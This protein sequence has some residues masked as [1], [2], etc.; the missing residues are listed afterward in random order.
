MK[1]FFRN[2]RS[3]ISCAVV[4]AMIGSMVVSCSYDDSKLW[5]EIETIKGELAEL[6]ASVESELAAIRAI[7]E[8]SITIK[9]VE[10]QADGSKVITLSDN[11]K[12]TVYPKGDKVPSDI[13]T[14]VDID[15]VKYW[16]MFDKDGNAYPIMVNNNYVKVADVAPQ[17]RINGDAIEISFDGGE[18][19]LTTGYTQSAADSIISNIE[20]VYSDW[21]TD[22]KGNPLALYSVI[23]LVDGSVV[24]VGMQNGKLVLPYDTVFVAYETTTP[25][26]IEVADAA[27]FMTTTPDGWECD[28]EHDTKSG[29]MTLYFTAP[30]EA[31]VKSGMAEAEGVA[32][33]FVSFNSGSAAIASIKLSTKPATV[34][35]TTKGV[36]IEAAYG[37][38]YLLCGM[39]AKSEYN[40]DA[41]ARE[42][43]AQLAA[44]SSTIEGIVQIAFT[45]AM[46]KFV[47]YEELVKGELK[48]GAEYVF[49]CVAPVANEAGDLS[50][51][52]NAISTISKKY[53]AV[54]FKV[55]E[56][57][58]FDVQIAF[59]VVGS[60]PYALDYALASEFDAKE[61]AAHYTANP[62]YLV[63]SHKDMSYEGSFLEL[64]G[65]NRNL[66]SGSRYVAWYVAKN[67]N[68]VYTEDNILSWEFSTMS[69]DASGDIEIIAGDAV[70]DYDSI[71]V[72]LDTDEPHM[73]IYY[74][75]MPSYMASAYPD[76]T[77]IIEMLVA[78]GTK[79]VTDG[80]VKARY[81]DCK[82]GDKIT[83]FAVAVDKAGKLGKPFKQEY[84][85]KT[86]EYNSLELRLE[87]V[88]SQANNT[89]IKV[90]S[91]GAKSFRYIYAPVK[92][93]EWT[94]MFGGS[95]SK[96]GE[97]FVKNPDSSYIYDTADSNHALVDGN[98]LI[99]GLM[100]DLEYVVVVVA[101]DEKGLTSKPKSVYF[102]PT[103]NIGKFVYKSDANWAVGKPKLTLGEITE[104]GQYYQFVWY[105][106][107]EPGYTAYTIAV[108]PA[109]LDE[110]GCDTPEKIVNFILANVDEE[111][112][113]YNI[114][115]TCEYSANGYSYTWTDVWGDVFVEENLPGVYNHCK[116]GIKD[117][118]M[119]YTTWKDENGNFHE[120]FMYDP[121]AKREL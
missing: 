7:V 73:M 46:S 118:T 28:V 10:Q 43:N 116:I 95:A 113:R 45:E 31:A 13:V 84:V 4:A 6:R 102:T 87:L 51:K 39:V 62:D 35:F 34:N 107:P 65:G 120:P 68:G 44:P 53:T 96:A 114:G 77:Y 37:A 30:T 11:T 85:T 82:S 18:T 99:S 29:R 108:Q 26:A 106:T 70:C 72:M 19:W 101:V 86:I 60:E 67:D 75:A 20:V 33:L 97:F 71:E 32:K 14:I 48:A 50:V 94:D 55:V 3:I 63:A 16:G 93:S 110:A 103:V 56:A 81:D 109:V 57:S 58:F 5:G 115:N 42:C 15:G 52:A 23:T 25:F 54:S 112:A 69:F 80:A 78:E 117:V 90:T 79:V 61:I 74:N 40:A 59:E 41:I 47:S 21:Q 104:K 9:S 27:D 121:T 8:G 100:A 38:N 89:Q 92:S 64:F 1:A 36:N 12:I 66:D 105:I 91:E 88:E 111:D 83:F 49:W 17:T 119:I 2:I 98:I 22:A 24:K 76:D